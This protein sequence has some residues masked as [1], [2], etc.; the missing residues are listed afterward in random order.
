MKLQPEYLSSL[1]KNEKIEL[2]ALLEEQRRREAR[3]DLVKYTKQIIIP[4]TPLNDEDECEEFYPDNITPARHHKVLLGVLQS[5]AEDKLIY[6]GQVVKN[7]IILAPPGS[8]KST[9]ASLVFPTW[10]MGYKPNS[11]IIMAT[12]GS[13]LANKF[14]RKCRSICKSDEYKRIFDAELVQGNSAAND[15][16]ITNASTYMCGGVL[17][18]ITGNRAD[19]LIID[20]PFKGR[21]EADSETIRKKVK[22]EYRDSLLT[23]LK[24]KGWQLIINTRWHEDDLCGGILPKDYKGDSGFFK[25]ADE[26]TWYVLNFQ[27]ECQNDTDPLKRKKGEFLWTDWFPSEWWEQT[28]KTHAGYSWSALYQGIPTPEEGSFFKR[29]WFRRYR[30]G[31]EPRNLNKY[32]AG[33]YAVTENEG[34]FSE[35]GVCGFD[36][37]EDLWV[38]DWW[39]G[40]VAPNV[41]IDELINLVSKHDPLVSVAEGGLIRRSIEPF[42]KKEMQKQ[43]CYFRQEWITSNKNKAANARAFQGLASQGKIWIPNCS[44]GDE[45]IEQLISFPHGKYDDKVD[46]CGLFGRILDQ[47]YA[48]SGIEIDEEKKKDSYGLEE[49]IDEEDWKLT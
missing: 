41:W 18:G 29:E 33:D 13:D 31:E 42:L 47:T 43:K 27:A 20:D 21:E 3:N 46:V 37:N 17:S 38:L 26:S 49:D 35:E 14:G 11:N 1:T 12:Y 23:R 32:I 40:Q 5:L 48:P 7:V 36:E 2:L 30:F 28:K 44:W 4:G 9:Y 34:D 10:F 45:L 8:A 19:G 16:S 15:W 6:K 24:P 22:E 39:S 25:A